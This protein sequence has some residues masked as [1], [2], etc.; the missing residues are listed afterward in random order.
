VPVDA[1]LFGQEVLRRQTLAWRV[2]A[3]TNG[4]GQLVGDAGP[5]AVLGV[6]EDQ[7]GGQDF[8]HESYTAGA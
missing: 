5:E 4:L 1:E 8:C 6:G 7:G 2:G 3:L